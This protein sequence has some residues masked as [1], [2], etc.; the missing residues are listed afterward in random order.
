MAAMDAIEIADGNDR[1]DQPVEA[2]PLVAHDNEGMGGIRFGHGGG[3]SR[4]MG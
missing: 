2:G 3:W 4:S 1:P